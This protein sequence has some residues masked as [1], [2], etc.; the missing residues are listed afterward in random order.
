M[1]LLERVVREGVLPAPE[2]YVVDF[3]NPQRQAVPHA[4]WIAGVGVILAVLMMAQRLYTKIF[5]TGKFQ[6]DDALL[7]LA[8]LISFTTVGLC[9]HMFASGAG[10]VHGWEID[11]TTFNIFMMDV[12]LAAAIYIVGGSLAKISLLIF[13]FRLSPQR[14]FRTATWATLF[15]I[16]GYT[17][18]IFFALVFACNP[19]AMNYDINVQTGTCINRPSLYIAT[20]VVNIA[21]DIVLFCLPLP[22]VVKLQVPRRQKLGLLMIFLLGSIIVEANLF[23]VCAA[24]P[25]LRKF[26]KHVAPRLIGEST[27]GRN[28]KGKSGG[29]NGTHP[30][31]ALVTIGSVTTSAG[32]GKKGRRQYSQFD[33]AE[34]SP[35]HGQNECI[36]MAGYPSQVVMDENGEE[37]VW[38]DDGS[39]R[40]MMKDSARIVQTSTVTVEY[41]KRLG[42]SATTPF[43]ADTIIVSLDLEI[44]EIGIASLDTRHTFNPAPEN[45][46][47]TQ[48]INTHQFSTLNASKDF[49]HCDAADFKESK[50]VETFRVTPEQV[51][52]IVTSA[53]RVPE[54][55]N[56][57]E[58]PST[59][60][61]RRVV[62]V[63]HSIDCDLAILK[64][65]G[66]KLYKEK[67]VVAI[68]DT[69]AISKEIITGE[70]A[71]G[72]YSLAG[73]LTT[74]GC[75]H[76]PHE[77]HN[78]SNDAT[79][80]L[81]AM[82]MLAVVWTREYE[83]SQQS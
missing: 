37:R 53:V 38:A 62:I 21:S 12:Y 5:L 40:A 9:V 26:L 43:I 54:L 58:E 76:K 23:I 30:P 19:I 45:L 22:I 31:S 61:L 59:S 35:V 8:W 55:G 71:T 24:L 63:G 65:I 11:S 4:Y 75:P 39:E 74:L 66:L 68:L 32:M 44:K 80:T 10:G 29:A 34:A 50:F 83:R 36:V 17:I 20:A 41:H 27:Y 48:R 1:P 33:D 7:V 49:E 67:N 73:V 64:R 25:T 70:R 15:F 82:L 81:R 16:S 56:V 52:P 78:A 18:G 14:W 2:G 51:I 47:G 6:L 79:Y 72:G 13:Y 3:D 57:L 69:F 60:K 46:Q 28:S 42:E 77:L